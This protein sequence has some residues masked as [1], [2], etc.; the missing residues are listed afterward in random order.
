MSRAFGGDLS[1]PCPCG[2]GAEGLT[3]AVCC[4]PL[5]RGERLAVTA[6]ELMRSRYAAFATGDEDYLVRTWHPRTRP[7]RVG[8]DPAT[9]WTGLTVLRTHGGGPDEPDGVV[10]FVARW[11]EPSAGA[12]SRRGELHEVSRFARRAGRWLYV[13]GEHR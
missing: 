13:D 2:G 11:T 5:H 6:E 8:L 12:G 7:D 3:Y 1:T 9:R 10:E 4:A